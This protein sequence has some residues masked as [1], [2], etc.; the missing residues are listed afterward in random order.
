MLVVIIESHDRVCPVRSRCSNF[1]PV[2][3]SRSVAGPRLQA[4]LVYLWLRTKYILESVFWFGDFVSFW[5]GCGWQRLSK[6]ANLA[7][8]QKFEIGTNPLKT[9]RRSRPPIQTCNP[10]LTTRPIQTCDQDLCTA[11]FKNILCME[12]KLFS[13]LQFFF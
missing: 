12:S 5:K 1:G 7:A 4:F 13:G 2:R 6:C 9:H 11:V 10:D 8:S 3:S